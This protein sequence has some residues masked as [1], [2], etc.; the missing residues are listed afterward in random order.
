MFDISLKQIEAICEEEG[1]YINQLKNDIAN[2]K[3]YLKDTHLIQSFKKYLNF[4]ESIL[5]SLLKFGCQP[6]F[7]F[8]IKE[9]SEHTSFFKKI[10][11]LK[12]SK[13]PLIQEFSKYRKML[14]NTYKNLLE[15]QPEAAIIFEIAYLNKASHYIK[16]CIKYESGNKLTKEILFMKSI[17]TFL[18]NI[19]KELSKNFPVPLPF[20]EQFIDRFPY[21]YI[22]E[23]SLSDFEPLFIARGYSL[24]IFLTVHNL[25]LEKISQIQVF[26]MLNDIK[27]KTLLS[28][29][30]LEECKFSRFIFPTDE[31]LQNLLKVIRKQAEKSEISLIKE[32]KEISLFDQRVSEQTKRI[33][34]EKSQAISKIIET[35]NRKP[36]MESTYQISE[37]LSEIEKVCL[38]YIWHLKDFFGK[39]YK[40]SKKIEE[41]HSLQT[42]KKNDMK[43]LL[44][45]EIYQENNKLTKLCIEFLKVEPYLD[46]IKTRIE[47]GISKNILNLFI[48][49]K[50]GKIKNS[51]KI[52]EILL[53][54]REKNAKKYSPDVNKIINAY[55]NSAKEILLPI[56]ICGLLQKNIREWPQMEKIETIT[57]SH[58]YD[59]AN[60]F[61]I[62]GIPKGKFY[63][64][65]QK[66]KIQS[67]VKTFDTTTRSKLVDICMKHFQKVVTVLIYD[68]R[69]SSFMT[70]KLQNAER[71][72]MIIKNFHSKMAK[73]AKEYGAFLLKDIGDGGIIW[74][75]NNSKELYNSIY[76]ESTTKKYKKLRYSLMSQ[77]GL[78]LQKS[79]KSSEKA[80]LCAIS[81]VQA[82]EKFIKDNYIKYRDWFSDVMEKELIVKGTT[83]ALFPPMLRSLFRLGIGIASGLPSRDVAIG[84]N[85]F[86]DPDLRGILVNEAKFLSEGRDPE[87][88]VILAD[89]D[90]ILNLLFTSSK[91]TFGNMNGN[92]ISK[93]DMMSKVAEIVKGKLKSGILNFPD[94]NF[95]VEPYQILLLD[96]FQQVNFSTEI[97]KIDESGILYNQKENKIKVLYSIKT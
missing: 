80:I 91:F 89:H 85:A 63:H 73:I 41:N 19:R 29:K 10:Y 74:F 12:G 49:S 65:S 42:F 60:Y 36:L 5:S 96:T 55:I 82:A 53:T 76:R 69:G 45:E 83:Y 13:K 75:G 17:L 39:S 9:E 43:T 66:G 71:E 95:V 1:N 68:I 38:D 18:S 46:S 32:D 97:F 7:E 67:E 62:Y 94:K 24:T 88:S 72:Q 26:E 61:G 11:R 48:E 33:I 81:M 2:Q 92:M 6:F 93:E 59:Q 37:L 57:K 8:P 34:T 52:G 14:Y 84:P 16:E 87:H 56:S 15:K 23:H 25:L 30:N 79:P 51:E 64:F 35:K 47:K 28:K 50:N 21:S 58:L 40:L 22:T 31:Q 70:L 90:T 3:N 77:E 86:G 78:F 20:F 44:E 4:P 27:K 54:F